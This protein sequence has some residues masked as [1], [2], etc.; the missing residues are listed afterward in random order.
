MQNETTALVA[1]NETSS[2]EICDPIYKAYYYYIERGLN[3]AGLV[4]NTLN[5]I[6]YI[7]LISTKKA[8]GNMYKYLVVKSII[9]AYYSLRNLA[10]VLYDSEKTFGLQ[11]FL[12]A[13]YVHWI[14]VVY[15]GD[16]A[17][18]MSILCEVGA[19]FSRYRKVSWSLTLTT[20]SCLLLRDFSFFALTIRENYYFEF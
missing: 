16:I 11:R 19:C 6:V 4:L 3:M 13:M 18:L 1:N 9:D 5:T 8:R 10:Y 12:F 15:G 7:R 2:I 14:F 20:K 17:Q